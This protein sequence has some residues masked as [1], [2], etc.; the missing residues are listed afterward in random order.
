MEK[1]KLNDN[2]NDLIIRETIMY[3]KTNN[4]SQRKYEERLLK[5]V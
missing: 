4:H 1:E 5:L 2:F 3:S